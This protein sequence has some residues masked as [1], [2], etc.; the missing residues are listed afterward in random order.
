MKKLT[1]REIGKILFR[2]F[3]KDSWGTVDTESFRDPK[4]EEEADPDEDGGLMEV[5]DR[6]AKILNERLKRANV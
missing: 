4:T 1:G 6:V 5:L 3:N 2:E